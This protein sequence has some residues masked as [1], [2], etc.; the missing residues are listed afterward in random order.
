METTLCLGIETS[1]DETALALVRGDALVDQVLASQVDAHALF[2]GV[3]PELASREHYRYI[4]PLYALLAR[5]NRLRSGEVGI[6][7]V[8]RGPGLLGCLLVGAAFAKGLALSGGAR[9]IGVNHLHGHLLAPGLEQPL[10]FPAMG[11]LISGGHTHLY[12]MHSPLDMRIM[13]RTL[14]DAAGEACDKFA[15]MLHLPYPGGALLD[16]LSRGAAADGALFPRPYVRNTSLD[17]SFSG[18]KTAAMTWLAARPEFAAVG[19]RVSL[20]GQAEATEDFR[21]L[22]ASYLHAVADTLRI[23]TERALDAWRAQGGPPPAC[24]IV[25]GGVAA[26]SRVRDMM[27]RTAAGRGLPL[28]LPSPGLC[29]DNAAMI[30]YAGGLLARAGLAHDLDVTVVPRGR[31]VPDDD[32]VSA[33]C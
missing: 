7:A 1:C 24:L 29:A 27:E 8:A 25:A 31:R 13:G 30:A 19:R 11:L 16:A 14:D 9:L 10:R 5:R 32:Y 22:C 4:G 17:F 33:P 23:K 20:Y 18:L 3:V 26:N 15:R 21:G 12:R 2:G 6:V 28:I